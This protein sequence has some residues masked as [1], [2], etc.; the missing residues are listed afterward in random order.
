[1]KG[2]YF[3][4]VAVLVFLLFLGMTGYRVL[5]RPRWMVECEVKDNPGQ[6]W[7]M[8]VATEAEANERAL[9]ATKLRETCSVTHLFRECPYF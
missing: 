4:W 6:R 1:M 8:T 7:N 5:C 9:E 2:R 3:V